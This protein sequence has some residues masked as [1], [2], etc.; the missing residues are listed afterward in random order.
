MEKQKKNK[1]GRPSGTKKRYF[2]RKVTLYLSD[3]EYELLSDFSQ[4]G[5][6]DQNYSSATRFL[7]LHSLQQWEKKGQK[8]VDLQGRF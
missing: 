2:N 3:G 7:L 8:N 4:R 5:W 6:R 1:G